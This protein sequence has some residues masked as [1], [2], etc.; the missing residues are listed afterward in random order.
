MEFMLYI[1]SEVLVV[2]KPVF[3]HEFRNYILLRL[4][5]LSFVKDL[6]LKFHSVNTFNLMMIVR[7]R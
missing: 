2:G 7:F 3:I 4:F 1:F 5:L 6:F